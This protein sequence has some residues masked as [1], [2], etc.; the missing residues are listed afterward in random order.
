MH[1]CAIN[2]AF[3]GLIQKKKLG[4]SPFHSTHEVYAKATTDT[5]QEVKLLML[6]VPYSLTQEVLSWV[7]KCCDMLQSIISNDMYN[8]RTCNFVTDQSLPN[9]SQPIKPSIFQLTYLKSNL[10]YFPPDTLNHL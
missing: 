9:E 2:I 10:S 7:C 8:V 5:Q 1:S 6:H 4:T 3:H